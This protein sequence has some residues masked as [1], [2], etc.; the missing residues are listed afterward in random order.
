M[1]TLPRDVETLVL[2]GGTTGS[3]VAGLLA[4]RGRGHVLVIEA[5]P[6]HGPHD[7]G[8]WPGDLLNAAELGQSHDWGYSSERTYAD[9]TVPFQRARVIGGCSSHNGCAAIWGHRAD[10]DALAAVTGEPGWS[11][12]ALLPFF[13]E[14]NRRMRVVHYADA[15]TTPFHAAALAAAAAAGIPVGADLNDLDDPVAMAL[16]PSNVPGGTRWNAA[17]AYLDPVRTRGNLTIA[18]DMLVDRLII[19]GDRVAGA[20]AIG[21]DGPVEIR[22]SRTIVA[23]GAYGSP[24]I[25]LRSGIGDPDEVRAAGVTPR[26]ALPGVGR[27][28]H[29]HPAICLEYAGTPGLIAVMESFERDHWMPEEQTIAKLRSSQGDAAFDLHMYPVGG[30]SATQPGA[31][32]WLIWAACMTPRSRG[33]VCLRSADPAVAPLIDHRYLSDPDGHDR[34]VLRDGI[35]IIRDVAARS[36][37]HELLGA[38]IAPGPAAADMA[39]LDRFLDGSVSHYYHPVGTCAMGTDRSA[40]AVVDGRGRIHGLRDG[41]VADCAIL[42]TVPRANTN[43]P[44]V[45]IGERIAAWLLAGA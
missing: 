31:W 39:A 11:T 26:H 45:V 16:S 43:I 34:A 42:P 2:G 22:A 27:N 20:I 12:D 41:Y 28:L 24:A 19:E 29:D 35:A 1:T 17:F 21:P 23:G 33:S 40:G 37:L 38:E 5:G 32:S 44:A 7:S 10:Y 8:R 30:R 3:V 14:A 18:G 13:H 9:R 25:L 6:D 4:E 15:D 36:P